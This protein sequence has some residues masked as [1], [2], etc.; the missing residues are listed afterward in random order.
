MRLEH[1]RTLRLRQRADGVSRSRDGRPRQDQCGDDDGE[2]AHERGI[3]PQTD[4]SR[5][6]PEQLS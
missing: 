6:V 4:A 2:G 3:V 5:R 1:G